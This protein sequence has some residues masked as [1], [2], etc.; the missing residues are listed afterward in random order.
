M[1]ADTGASDCRHTFFL[2]HKLQTTHMAEFVLSHRHSEAQWSE[3]FGECHS[4]LRTR[5]LSGTKH[6]KHKFSR[7][8]HW[9]VGVT[10]V[11]VVYFVQLYP[12]VC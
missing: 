12:V 1:I 7:L 10:P 2:H 5:V 3:T 9:N 11:V 6:H 4:K 8:V